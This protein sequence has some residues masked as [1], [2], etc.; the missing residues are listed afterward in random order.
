M[1][2]CVCCVCA[3]SLA[4]RSFKLFEELQ[5]EILKPYVDMWIS[6]SLGLP[7]LLSL[8]LWCTHARVRRLVCGVDG[9]SCCRE[10]D[11]KIPKPHKEG[12]VVDGLVREGW[13][14]VHVR[15]AC[16]EVQSS[17]TFPPSS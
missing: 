6:G 12:K 7:P 16:F 13:L 3:G 17:P 4:S 15:T 8:D 11:G 2:V 14:Q 5:A 1:A 9:M 10:N